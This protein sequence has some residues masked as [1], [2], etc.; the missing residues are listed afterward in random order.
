LELRLKT[1][2]APLQLEVSYFTNEDTRPR[3]LPLHRL[4][5]PWA[6]PRLSGEETA[7]L[8]STHPALAKGNWSRGRALFLGEATC[9]KCH[10]M[11]GEGN[12]IGPDLSNLPF[13]D[14]D[15]VLRDITMPSATI[16]PDYVTYTVVLKDGRTL[17]GLIQAR[18]EQF[19]LTDSETKTFTFSKQEIE[20]MVVSKVSLMPEGLDKQLGPGK[21]TDLMTFLLT[22][23]PAPARLEIEGAPPPRSMEEV[24]AI[25][26]QSPPLTG[27]K[28]PLRILLSAGPKDH[29]PGEHDYPLWQRRWLQ[30]LSMAENVSV[31]AVQGWPNAQVLARTDLL[32]CYSN[33]PGWSA[34]RAKELDA[35]LQRGGGLVL[36]HFA[37]DGHKDVQEYARQI[38]LAWQGGASKYRHGA[39]QL[40]FPDPRH[41]ITRGF[42]SLALVDES[43]WNL[44]GN[45][46]D[47]HLLAT[48]NE[49]G[50]ARP[51]LWTKEQGKGR[52]FVSIPGHYT[53]SFDDPLFRLLLLRGMAWSAGEPVER[54]ESLAT[55]G[56]RMSE[57]KKP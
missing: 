13:R 40:A 34:E 30:I 57:G 51:L 17:T 23:P 46:Q 6:K 29:G 41:P 43:Y 42:S 19:T 37:V 56:A 31:D 8:A 15:S 14:Y 7:A 35:Y 52:V 28:R 5:L 36:V 33:N 3:A 9:S 48:G 22:Q 1:G 20:E 39:L 21:L 10:M 32:V 25:L 45:Q 49:E 47:V 24:Q 54:F 50:T 27:P 26:K 2:G 38:G 12:K 11:R 16:N 55:V 53:W 4:H 44:A 18:G